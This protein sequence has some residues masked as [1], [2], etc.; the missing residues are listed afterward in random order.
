MPTQPPKA[1]STARRKRGFPRT[2]A[3]NAEFF[4][5][6]YKNQLCYDFG[7]GRWLIW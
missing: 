6:Q 2:D 7:R 1:N 5:D 3:G 4:A